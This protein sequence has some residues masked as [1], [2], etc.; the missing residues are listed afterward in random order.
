ATSGFMLPDSLLRVYGERA[1]ARSA[2]QLARVAIRHELIELYLPV[3]PEQEFEEL[4]LF[5]ESEV[6]G[7]LL[8]HLPEL[9]RGSM[10]I[11]RERVEGVLAPQLEQLVEEM[12]RELELRQLGPTG[13]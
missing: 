8:E 1:R 3:F 11:A 13:G 5:Y 12:G 4:A 7:K 2:R 10:A 6:G 9:T